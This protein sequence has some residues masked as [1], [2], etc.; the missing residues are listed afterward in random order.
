MSNIPTA[1]EIINCLERFSEDNLH[2]NINWKWFKEC[3]SLLMVLEN[4]EA[5]LEVVDKENRKELRRVALEKN[6]VKTEQRQRDRLERDKRDAEKRAAKIAAQ[7]AKHAERMRVGTE[8]HQK[9]EQFAK[10]Y[11]AERAAASAR[12]KKVDKMLNSI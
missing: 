3:K 9:I 2:T 10:S 4:V 7:K 12:A 6:R 8:N 1:S 5:A 11:Q